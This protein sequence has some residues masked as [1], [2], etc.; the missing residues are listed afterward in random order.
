MVLVSSRL[1]RFAATRRGSRSAAFTPRAPLLPKVRGQFAEFLNQG[2]LVHLSFLSQPT[3]VGLRY[4]QEWSSVAGLSR[5]FGFSALAVRG[6]TPARTRLS[7]CDGAVLPP[8][9]PYRLGRSSSDRS[10]YPSASRVRPNVP[11]LVQDCLP[12]VHR[13]LLAHPLRPD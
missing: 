11:F 4:G 5:L 6:A 1:G 10:A 12:V 13:V 8:P 3:C 7:V 2:S 9:S